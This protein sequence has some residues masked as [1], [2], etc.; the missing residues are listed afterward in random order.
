LAQGDDPGPHGIGSG[1]GSGFRG[2]GLW[3]IAAVPPVR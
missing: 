1:L 3:H 2:F